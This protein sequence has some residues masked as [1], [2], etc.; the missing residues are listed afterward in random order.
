MFIFFRCN[1]IGPHFLLFPVNWKHKRE[2]CAS[3]TLII[4][5]TSIRDCVWLIGVSVVL[6][7]WWK[8]W[9]FLDLKNEMVLHFRVFTRFCIF[10][11]NKRRGCSHLFVKDGG[12]FSFSFVL[13]SSHLYPRVLLLPFLFSSKPKPKSPKSNP[14]FQNLFLLIRIKSHRSKLISEIK[15]KLWITQTGGCG[16]ISTQRKWD[17]E[18]RW[19]REGDLWV[20]IKVDEKNR[21]RY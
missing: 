9:G 19:H 12:K 7:S 14:R 5:I 11:I 20:I 15:P 6:D 21:W 17:C 13:F 3:G 18:M 16:C 2:W 10:N 8:R 4:F 1:I